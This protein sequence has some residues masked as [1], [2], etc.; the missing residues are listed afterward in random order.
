MKYPGLRLIE[1]DGAIQQVS[2]Q[3]GTSGAWTTI[4]RGNELPNMGRSYLMMRR[5]E[6]QTAQS[7]RQES[8][9]SFVRPI[10]NKLRSMS[11]STL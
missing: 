7:A 9:D 11:R 5:L 2:L 4:S 10:L 3:V 8:L 6:R 1:L